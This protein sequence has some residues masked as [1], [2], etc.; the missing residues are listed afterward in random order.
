MIAADF[1]SYLEQQEAVDRL[2]ADPAGWW[3]ASILN[4]AGVAWFSSDRSVAEYADEIW[5][6]APIPARP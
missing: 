5:H 1:S 6:A 2:W 4:T 3:Q